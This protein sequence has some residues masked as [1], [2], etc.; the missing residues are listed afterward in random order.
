M[1]KLSNTV[2]NTIG[3][4]GQGAGLF[5][6]GQQLGG[7]GAKKRARDLRRSNAAEIAAAGTEAEKLEVT[8][9]Q[10]EEAGQTE[11]A[12]RLRRTA[13]TLLEADEAKAKEAQ[14]K[15]G[16][17]L[18]YKSTLQ[19]LIASSEDDATKRKASMLLAAGE[20]GGGYTQLAEQINGLTGSALSAKDRY[21][22]VGSQVFDRQSGTF[23]SGASGSG[24]KPTMLQV[25]ES[26]GP[27]YTGESLKDAYNP[28][29]GDLDPDKLV[30]V[31]AVEAAREGAE[32]GQRNDRWVQSQVKAI[33]DML[34]TANDALDAAGRSWGGPYEL[35][36]YAP[37]SAAKEL[38]G[39][40]KTMQSKLAFDRLEEMRDNSKTG[41]ALG[42]VSN[43]EL[44]LLKSNLT[45]LDPSAG[46]DVFNAQ[47]QKVIKHYEGL[48]KRLLRGGDEI[49]EQ[50][51]DFA[52]EIDGVAYVQVAPGKWMKASDYE[53]QS[54]SNMGGK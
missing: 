33:D 6:V 40:V 20:R 48:R 32:E 42:Q 39:Y 16:T 49:T 30:S 9:R 12:A 19:D 11:A 50:D 8:A 34:E 54:D 7:L 44:D 21:V 26:L 38:A 28:Q 31:D 23:L 2:L 3:Q 53:F 36:K 46:D 45:A 15:A 52:K 43:I 1:P 27:I 47:V 14:A 29:T 4:A 17:D 10:L 35:T 37:G 51:S 22:P 41:G 18:Y 5:T 13:S 24:E 25:V